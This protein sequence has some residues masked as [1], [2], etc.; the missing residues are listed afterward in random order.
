MAWIESHQQLENHPKLYQLCKQTGWNLDEALGKLHRFWWWALHYAED[1][2]LSKYNPSQFLDR[3]DSKIEPDKLF[4]ILQATGFIDKDKKIHD[5]IDYAGR[6]LT[7]KYRT[8]NP[9]KLKKILGKYKSDQRRTKVGL[10]SD[11][12]PNQPTLP[13]QTK[14]TRP[15]QDSPNPVHR[16]IGYWCKLYQENKELIYSVKW[17]V[18]GRLIKDKYNQYEKVYP[19]RG[20]QFI[21]DVMDKFFKIAKTDEWLSDKIS[22]GMFSTRFNETSQGVIRNER[23]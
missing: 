18:E 11:N 2:D 23:D 8:S 9:R 17:K 7:G 12:P 13:N 19:G 15:L 14:L 16:L 20:E 1:G 6:Y 5:W 22:I 4:S 3:L 21:R 10:K